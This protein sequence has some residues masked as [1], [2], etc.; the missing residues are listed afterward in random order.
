MR[1]LF[2]TITF[3]FIL[4]SRLT[5]QFDST[6]IAIIYSQIRKIQPEGAVYYADKPPMQ[7]IRKFVNELK[8]NIKR[9]QI[10]TFN[11]KTII[12]NHNECRYILA[13]LKKAT[14]SIHPDKLFDNSTRVNV[15][16]IVYMVDRINYTISDSL[17]KQLD[18]GKNVSNRKSILDYRKWSFFFIKPIY[19]RKHTLMFAYFMYYTLSSGSEDFYLYIQ[20]NENWVKISMIPLGVW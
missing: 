13:E 14:K 19:L 16:S 4:S 2:V 3:M 15:D 12:L 6:D 5:G 11:G 7:I 9:K 8:Q 17:L 10:R 1:A 20:K 18:T